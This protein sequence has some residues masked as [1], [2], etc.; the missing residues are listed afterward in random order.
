[1]K[2]TLVIFQ[3]GSHPSSHI[4][5][6]SADLGVM[7]RLCN[8]GVSDCSREKK[9]TCKEAPDMHCFMVRSIKLHG[10]ICRYCGCL[11]IPNLFSQ[12]L[13]SAK[14]VWKSW[15]TFYSIAC[16]V[17][18]LCCELNVITQDALRVSDV[19]RS[20]TKSLLV[21]MHIVVIVK[22]CVNVG[23]MVVNSTKMLD[24]LRRAAVLEKAMN[25]PPCL[26]CGPKRFV[27]SDVRR[28]IIF[29]AYFCSY[30][31][32]VHFQANDLYNDPNSGWGA[33]GVGLRVAGFF[34]AIL[35]FV[36]DSLHFSALKYST[37]V[38]RVYLKSQL[39]AL[40]DC[41]SP[42][43]D[44]RLLGDAKKIEAVR[45]R[46]SDIRDLKTR[47]NDMWHWSIVT[48]CA[49]IILV[50]CIAIYTVCSEGFRR[51]EL[52]LALAYSVYTAF[53][54]TDM[55]SISQ[56]LSSQVSFRLKHKSLA[57]FSENSAG[58]FVD[59]MFAKLRS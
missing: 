25:I 17:F 43:C 11:L 35:F 12:P 3:A 58:V 24:F 51:Q 19:K 34:A 6:N 42:A 4:L 18:F 54:F 41:V 23:S 15:Y 9:K 5:N 39:E 55:A 37:E 40:E 44:N 10:T 14:V 7:K 48:S 38:F 49:S 45:L 2:V 33:T 16:F 27:W 13:S 30:M 32:G 36:Y 50:E 31:M 53:E 26:C 1:M 46:I 52:W 59:Y 8:S 28:V 47:L 20:F 56:K 57:L 22:S 21:L 29:V